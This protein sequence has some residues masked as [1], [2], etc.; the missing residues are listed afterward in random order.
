MELARLSKDSDITIQT[1][2]I[3]Q[4]DKQKTPHKTKITQRFEKKRLCQNN[5][6]NSDCK[7]GEPQEGRTSREF[8]EKPAC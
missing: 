1:N 6:V 2:A 8:S 7:T 5:D 4:Q 3:I